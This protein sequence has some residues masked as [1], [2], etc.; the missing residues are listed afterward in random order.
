MLASGLQHN[1]PVIH[2]FQIPF[3]Y[4]L[5]QKLECSSVCYTIGPC[6]FS[7]LPA[8]DHQG[9]LLVLL[10]RKYGH[11]G[12]SQVA[13]VVKNLPAMQKPQEMWV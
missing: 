1:N 13:L 10:F 4:R 6:W 12:A 9:I 11:Q 8:L 5:L 3:P 2:F 7:P